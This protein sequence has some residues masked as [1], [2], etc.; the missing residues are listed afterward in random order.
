MAKTPAWVVTPR[1]SAA[2]AEWSDATGALWASEPWGHVLAGLGCDV[3]YAWH[4]RAS[5][6]VVLPVFRYGPLRVAA[7]GF[8]LVAPARLAEV[9]DADIV[10]LGRHARCSVVRAVESCVAKAPPGGVVLPEVWAELDRWPGERRRRIAKDL[11]FARRAT[12]GLERVDGLVDSAGAWALYGGTVARHGGQ[13]R[14]TA[15]YFHRL[16]ALAEHDCRLA[17]RSVIDADG[18]LRAFAI[19][20]R[21]EDTAYYLHAGTDPVIRER[22][23]N[24]ILLADLFDVAHGWGVARFD[25]MASPANQPG[26]VRYKRKWATDEGYNVTRDHAIGIVGHLAASGARLA[27]SRRS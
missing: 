14:Y 5:F 2:Q 26:L 19:A 20:A 27:R 1:P 24:D 3:L 12:V 13:M 10:A 9:T 8:P 11:A 7:L 15:D 4:C 22:G 18:R 17:A 23:V 25:L 21:H 16:A 6:G